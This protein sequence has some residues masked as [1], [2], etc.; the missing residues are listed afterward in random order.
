MTWISWR[1]QRTETLIAAAALTVIA[2]LLLPSGFSMADAY[3]HDALATCANQNTIVCHEAVQAFTNR[4][5]S[6]GGLLGWLSLV[7]GIIGVLLATPIILDLETGTVRFAWTQGVTR[8]RWLAIRLTVALAV[9]LISAGALTALITWWREPLDRLNGRMAPDVFDFEGV[10]SF[11]YVL[12]AFALTLAIGAVWRRT[13]PAVVVGLGGFIATRLVTQG[14]L[15]QRYVIP[16]SRIFPASAPGPNLTHAW[17]LSNSLSNRAGEPVTPSA[18]TIQK[19][20]TAVSHTTS[21]M[22]G[23]CFARHGAGFIHDVFLPASRFWTLQG[24]ET[25]LFAGAAVALTLFAAWWIH[26]RA[27]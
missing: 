17:L 4:Y 5:D 6:L 16:V 11:G 23:A 19:C 2:V 3:A 21:R 9:A 22:N 26:E 20:T 18:A 13:V 12:F 27:A 15:R 14:W 24:I 1:L 8:T 25:G 7:P 10:V